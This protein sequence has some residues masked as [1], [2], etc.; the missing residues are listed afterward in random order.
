[1][2]HRTH[3][4]IAQAAVR[5]GACAVQLRDKRASDEELRPIAERIRDL[6]RAAGVLFIVNDR[7]ELAAR[8][9]ADGVHVGDEDMPVAKAREILG[10]ERIIGRSADNV[11]EALRAQAEGADY[12]GLGPVYTTGTKANAGAPI[13]P[14]TI[15]AAKKVVS[16]PIVAIGGITAANIDAVIAAGADAVAVISAV[17]CAPDMEEVVR[18]LVGRFATGGARN[19]APPSL[20]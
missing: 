17:V 2:T 6:C 11:E 18:E 13:G 8:V 20:V 15:A 16:I 9:D 1:M 12:V 19:L 7:V 3:E 14:E 4:E 5:G 10:P